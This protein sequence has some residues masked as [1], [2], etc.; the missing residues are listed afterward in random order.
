MVDAPDHGGDLRAA[1][2]VVR[3]VDAHAVLE[4]AGQ[5]ARLIERGQ[6]SVVRVGK[7]RCRQGGVQ[8]HRLRSQTGHLNARHD[9]VEIGQQG[10]FGIALALRQL[11]IAAGPVLADRLLLIVSCC[12]EHELERLAHGDGV[13]GGKDAVAAPVDH[14]R[15]AQIGDVA[16]EPVLRLDVAISRR[17][18]S[19]RGDRG[20]RGDLLPLRLGDRI[21]R[22]LITN[23]DELA[24][25]GAQARKLIVLF[26]HLR[27]AVV[28]AAAQIHGKVGLVGDTV[29]L[30]DDQ[31]GKLLLRRVEVPVQIQ[32]GL[33]QPPLGKRG[34]CLAADVAPDAER[35]RR[36]QAGRAAVP[37]HDLHQVAGAG[38]PA[39][40][41]REGEAHQRVE[42]F[43]R[44][45][46][47]AAV[48]EAVDRALALAQCFTQQ[49]LCLLPGDAVG[50]G[51]G[52]AG[53][54]VADVRPAIEL[55]A[56]VGIALVALDQR[57]AVRPRA[58][59]QRGT[60]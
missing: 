26:R 33:L 23:L 28:G 41:Q 56:L 21:A 5:D 50:I 3:Q 20:S 7:G 59:V 13:L 36:L 24:V 55:V 22:D 29:L 34:V 57:Q 44:W 58:H 39:V 45:R 25:L 35:A 48:T 16:I 8:P 47:A 52:G 51:V 18:G 43:L 37:A 4:R 2:A 30:L 38:K 27:E 31:I 19:D 42:L 53:R 9:C 54:A 49:L 60:D 12:K 10:A 11:R 32:R 6:I 46:E 15:G 17:D 40:A 1:D 14:A